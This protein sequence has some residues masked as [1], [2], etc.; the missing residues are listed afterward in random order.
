MAILFY[1]ITGYEQGPNRSN[2]D[3][4]ESCHAQKWCQ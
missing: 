2:H 4:I 3:N 1:Q